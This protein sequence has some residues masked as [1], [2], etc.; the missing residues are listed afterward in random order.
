MRAQTVWAGRFVEMRRR[1]TAA[2]RTG[3]A[4]DACAVLSTAAAFLVIAMM[5]RVEP[6]RPLPSLATVMTFIAAYGLMVA[7][8]TRLAKTMSALWFLMPTR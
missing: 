1:M 6:G 8:C 3:N 5:Q 7:A 4:H 2:R